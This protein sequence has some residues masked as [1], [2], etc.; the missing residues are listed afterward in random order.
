MEPYGGENFQN[1][2][3]PTV[4]IL[5]QPNFFWPAMQSTHKF[6]ILN[7][8]ILNLTLKLKILPNEKNEK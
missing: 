8:E 4:S 2:T 1:A 6:Q 3:P 7:F 5:F